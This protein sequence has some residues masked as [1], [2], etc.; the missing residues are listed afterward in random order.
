MRAMIWV[1]S[2]V[3]LLWGGVWVV[4]SRAI[5][6]GTE[7]WLAAQPA[8][9]PRV[10]ASDVAV[11]GFPNR[12]D[13]RVAD[14]RFGDPVTGITWQAPFAEVDTLIYKPWHVIASLP[15]GQRINTPQGSATLDSTRFQASLRVTPSS[16]LPL[17]QIGLT[18]DALSLRTDDGGT[19]G[20]ASM[21]LAFAT[22]G[23]DANIYSLGIEALGLAPDPGFLAALPAR[24]TLPHMAEALRLRARLTFTAPLDRFAGETRPALSGLDI[25][26]AALTWGPIRAS[27]TGNLAADAEGYAEGRLAL[28]LTGWQ[29]ALDLAAAA[30]LLSPDQLSTAS[31][32]ASRAATAAGTP[33]RIDLPLTFANGRI[34]FGL[35]PLGPAPRLVP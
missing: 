8:D 21:R 33:D 19:T 34:S 22:E 1:V 25:A 30:G 32:L 3:A 16:A 23:D 31:E 35:F 12:L 20:L 9:G 15:P 11:Q 5:L 6:K 4:A 24:T 29:A 17:A 7:G 18:A 27:A 26:E 28:S 13:L 10:Q 2:I 14:P